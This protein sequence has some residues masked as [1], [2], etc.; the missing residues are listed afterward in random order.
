MG[1]E[2]GFS[3]CL[4]CMWSGRG[5]PGEIVEDLSLH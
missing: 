3:K 1:R 5:S 4:G 2:E